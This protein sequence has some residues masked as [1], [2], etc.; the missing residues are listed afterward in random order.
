MDWHFTP[1]AVPLFVGTAIMATISVIT[2]QRRTM[3]GAHAVGLMSLSAGIYTLG[4][5]LE[6]GSDT[7]SDVQFWLKIEYIGIATAPV[8]LFAVVLVYTSRE[9]FL[10]GLNFLMLLVIP[11]ITIIF[12]WT[13]PQHELI[14]RGMT[15]KPVGDRYVADFTPGVWYWTSVT[16]T[17]LL[18]IAGLVLLVQTYRRVTGLFRRQ[19]GII[20]VGSLIPFVFHAVYLSG[21]LPI[22]LDINPYALTLVAMILTWAILNVQFLDLMPVARQ[23]VFASM[24]D[25]VIVMDGRDRVVDLNPPARKLVTP[26]IQEYLGTPAAQVFPQWFAAAVASSNGRQ[27]TELVIDVQ[28]EKRHFDVRLSPLHGQSGRSEGRL[29]VLRDIT[30]RK[31][32]EEERERLLSELD[33]FAHT[34]AHDLKTPLTVLV[35]YGSLLE[36]SYEKLPPSEIQRSATLIARTSRKMSSIIDELLLLA[37]VRK[38]ED[39]KPLPLNM[40]TIVAEA[41]NRLSEMIA[42]SGATVTGPETWPAALGYAA[43]V[44]E[45]WVNYITNAIKY[46]GTPPQVELGAN[47]Q[48][49]GM[50]RFWVRD[51]GRGLSPEEQTQLFA[52]FSRLQQVRVEGFGLGLSIVRRIVEKLGGQAGVESTVGQGSV[53]SF[54]LPAAPP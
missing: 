15:L 43:W 17:W 40:A 48:P 41:R 39:V 20:L 5:A 44:E 23:T 9:Q 26:G 29:I 50:I 37:S 28:E 47:T 12:A 49:D 24:S 4:Y 34:V 16:Y 25:P 31:Q 8:F 13:N 53:F 38:M 18:L 7:L 22:E 46:G 3:R 1:Y 2:L 32:A 19:V 52:E 51:N 27:Q 45:I 30:E 42:A 35:G 10:T 21:V 11:V 36:E 33:A 6:L 14:W 54:T